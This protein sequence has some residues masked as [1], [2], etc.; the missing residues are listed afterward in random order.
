MTV[1]I[2]GAG[3][4]APEHDDRVEARIKRNKWIRATLTFM[5]GSLIMK[6]AASPGNRVLLDILLRLLAS[7]P[8]SFVKDDGC[9]DRHIQ[10]I[11]LPH[12]GNP[13]LH[14]R[15]GYPEV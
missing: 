5:D 7:L 8:N 13:D 15:L 14:I 10:G 4:K 6:S 12:H 2:R 3:S 11:Y 1:A 9:R